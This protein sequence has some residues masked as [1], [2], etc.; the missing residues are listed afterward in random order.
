MRFLMLTR[1][2]AVAGA[3]SAFAQTPGWIDLTFEGQRAAKIPDYAAAEI[4]FRAALA[5]AE[6]FGELDQRLRDSLSNLASVRQQ[7]GDLKEAE[8]LYRRRLSIE[9]KYSDPDAA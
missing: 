8:E 1:I 4:K 2:L 7:Q 3:V 9:Q 6:E 5:K